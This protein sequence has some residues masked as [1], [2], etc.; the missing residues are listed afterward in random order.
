MQLKIKPKRYGPLTV[1]SDDG[2]TLKFETEAGHHAQGALAPAA[3]AMSPSDLLLAALANCIAISMRMAAQQMALELGALQ[4]AAVAT[5]ATDL[6]N[7]FGR[8][9]VTV[10][11]AVP[12][13][14]ERVG[15]L[16][17]RTKDICTVSNTLGA[18]VELLLNP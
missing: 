4:V 3:H 18:E 15:E 11:S 6:P 13:D 12:V 10:R 2:T 7:R 8:F 17:K 1:R 16:L 9:D 5:K 14:P